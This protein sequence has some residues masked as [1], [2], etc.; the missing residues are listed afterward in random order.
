MLSQ[1]ESETRNGRDQRLSFSPDLALR[2]ALRVANFQLKKDNIKR[3]P[4]GTRVV[5]PSQR[6]QSLSLTKRIVASGNKIGVMDKSVMMHV[7]NF[8]QKSP[9]FQTF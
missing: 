4:L 7:H 1:H 9:L 6:S 3:K 5:G 8:V 2:S